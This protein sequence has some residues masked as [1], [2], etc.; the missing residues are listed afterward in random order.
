MYCFRLLGFQH[1]DF[2]AG[3]SQ[4]D[5]VRNLPGQ[6]SSLSLICN[7]TLQSTYSSR[8]L[9]IILKLRESLSLLFPLA[10]G[11]QYA[12]VWTTRDSSRSLVPAHFWVVS[13][14]QRKWGVFFLSFLSARK[15]FR[16]KIKTLRWSRAGSHAPTTTPSPICAA[17]TLMVC[18]WLY[19]FACWS[20]ETLLSTKP[21]YAVHSDPF[22]MHPEGSKHGG[23]K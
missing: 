9:L 18:T 21:S 5:P 23:N 4:N 20:H 6:Q 13:D 14:E 16:E 17:Q 15:A 7:W 19:T 12:S 22:L 11:I 8:L 2:Q 3:V 10:T 1:S